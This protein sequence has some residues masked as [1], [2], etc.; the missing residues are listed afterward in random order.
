MWTVGVIASGNELGLDEDELA[1]LSPDVLAA[2]LAAG[3][4]RMLAAG[5][6]YAVDSVNELWP[7][8]IEIDGRLAKGEAP[9]LPPVA[10][11]SS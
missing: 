2:R 5:A 11:R 8:L 10:P 7:V 1:A 9:P 6:H 4:E 3:K